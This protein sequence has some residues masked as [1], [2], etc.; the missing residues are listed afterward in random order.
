MKGFETYQEKK[1]QSMQGGGT[2]RME[3]QHRKGK[4]SARERLEVLLDPGSFEE[5]G[6]LV[7]HRCRDFGL[8]K[9]V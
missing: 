8:E 1:I 5:M 2:A 6:G 3:A 4:L 9:E 7:T